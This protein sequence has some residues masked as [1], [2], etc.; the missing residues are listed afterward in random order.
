M[1]A[2]ECLSPNNT[3][4]STKAPTPTQLRAKLSSRSPDPLCKAV[5]AIQSASKPLMAPRIA[6]HKGYRRPSQNGAMGSV[7]FNPL[8]KSKTLCAVVDNGSHVAHKMLD[9]NE[10]C[11]FPAFHFF[12]KKTVLS[13][14][15]T[16]TGLGQAVLLPFGA[17]ALTFLSLLHPLPTCE[18]TI[19]HIFT[20]ERCLSVHFSFVL[21]RCSRSGF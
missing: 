14:L 6:M 12:F 1:F 10:T 2:V 7:P 18:Q 5:V 15:T 17:Y 21:D 4:H 20:L 3:F 11:S 19:S 9:C 13:I 8:A 16:H